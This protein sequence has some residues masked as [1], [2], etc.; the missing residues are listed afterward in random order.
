MHSLATKRSV[1]SVESKLQV[2]APLLH[3][4]KPKIIQEGLARGVDFSMTH[5]CYDPAE[6]G[7][8]CE[9]CDSCQ[10]RQTAFLELGFNEDPAVL[11]YR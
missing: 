4:T 6:N 7:A 11:R 10:L 9:S 8:P 2:H 1:E 5:S 3:W